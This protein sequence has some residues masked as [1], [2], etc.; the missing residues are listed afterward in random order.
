MLGTFASALFLIAVSLLLGGAIVRFSGRRDWSWVA[1]PVGLAAATAL[2]WWAV[3]LPGEGAA[4]LIVITIAALLSAGYL[5]ARVERLG[6]AARLGAL[7]LA[8]ACAAMA[9]PFLAA[10][11]FGILGTGFNVDMSQHLFAAD[12]IALPLS[13]EPSLL[14][15]GYPV[16]PHALAVTAATLTDSDLAL[17]FSGV[18]IAIPVLLSLTA[19]AAAETLTRP[20]A[21]LLALAVGASYLVA[22]Y[23]AQGSFKEVFAAAFLVGFALWL[24][25]I[26]KGRGGEGPRTAI[27]LAAIAAGMLYAYS[28]PGL[29]WLLAALGCWAAAELYFRRVE[30]PP[31]AALRAALPVA[32]AGILLTLAL[33][34]PE[35]PRIADFGGKVSS[36]ADAS[37]HEP[38]SQAAAGIHAAAGDNDSGTGPGSAPGSGGLGGDAPL[39]FDDDLGN[40]FGQISPL[41]ALNVWP[42]G[43]FR[44]KPGDGA[45]PAAGF[46]LGSL[47]ALLA[48]GWGLFRWL[49]E[50]ELAIPMAL[51]G[52]LVIFLAARIASTPYTTAK[53]LEMIAPLAML[54]SARAVLQPRLP[55]G[56]STSPRVALAGFLV[57]LAFLLGAGVS[58]VLALSN[59]PIGPERYNAGVAKL[60][61]ETTGR[62]VL[63]LVEAEQIDD[64]HAGAYYSWEL[65]G[66]DRISVAAGPPKGGFSTPPPPGIDVVLIPDRSNG[67]P[68]AGLV[69][70]ASSRGATLWAPK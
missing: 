39:E 52:A 25:E 70:L 3:R 47:I 35:L 26:G 29:V 24:R 69:E 17:T 13:P 58:S 61:P 68:F 31:A 8:L 36:V 66:A 12:W 56:S 44:V 65:R 62:A 60:R 19:L 9:I 43:D 51:L 41:T 11:Q 32:L 45:V 1:A 42:S 16:G 2:A 4:G 37:S 49:R 64:R 48:L 5:W 27:P 53:A 18:T 10:G 57:G 6:V 33:A 46:Y 23:V 54:I 67:P 63:V 40:L 34:A 50:D 7:P 30:R 15:Q 38:G 21:A 55:E 14:S 28:A 59:T 20:R 22:S